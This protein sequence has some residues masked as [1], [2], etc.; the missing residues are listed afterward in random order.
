M[1]RNLQIFLSLSHLHITHIFNYTFKSGLASMQNTAQGIVT[2][3]SLTA[4]YICD[5]NYIY[6][7]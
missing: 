1:L 5:A 4:L 7:H 2:I 3:V 6:I